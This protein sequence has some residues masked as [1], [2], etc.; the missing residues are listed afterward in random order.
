MTE[1]KLIAVVGAT[2]SQGGG[3]VRAILDD[4]SGTYAV[5]A[6]TRSAKS[7]SAQA[8]AA[9]GAEVVEADL[10]DEASLRKAFEGAHGAFVVTNYWVTRTPAEEA[11]RTRAEMEL[12]QAENAA[13][14]AKDAGVAHVIWSTLEDTRL[15]FGETDRVPSLDDGR[16]KVPHF[17]AKGEAD[18]LFT[19]YGV[20]STFLRTTWYYDGL[21]QGLGPVRD[22]SGK[23]VF[24]L[25][26]ADQPLAGIA[27]EDIGRTA[28]AIFQRG[29]EF[30]GRTVSIAGDHLTGVQLAAALT[31]TLGEEVTYQPYTWDEYRALG[32]PMAVEIAN[33]FQ[34]Y[35]ENADQ[36]TGDRDLAAVR[37]LNPRLQSF[38]MWLDLHKDELKAAVQ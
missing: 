35:A 7:A 15:H 10:D 2:G 17:D 36:F 19:K 3:L 25:P 31:N 38:K 4:A 32:F 24:T 18:E 14:A 27:V 23:L 29:D 9:A 6:L 22:E 37:D 13:R 16:Y 5:R 28:F 21:T 11:A 1:R 20:P 34:Y 30:I 33:M 8:L 26:L 12:Q